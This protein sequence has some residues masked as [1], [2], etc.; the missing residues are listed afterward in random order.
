[1]MV[2]PCQAGLTPGRDLILLRDAHHP[3][4]TLLTMGIRVGR[5]RLWGSCGGILAAIGVT[6]GQMS[7]EAGRKQCPVSFACLFLILNRSS[8]RIRWSR[9]M[10]MSD[11]SMTM[12]GVDS[13]Y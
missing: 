8:S 1:M 6:V 13:L 5:D 7:D 4:P 3:V 11:P 9:I 12:N 2:W 10:K